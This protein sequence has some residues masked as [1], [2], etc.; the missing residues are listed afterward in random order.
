MRLH[1][2]CTKD[3]TP[4][5][6][7]GPAPVGLLPSPDANAYPVLSGPWASY[8]AEAD[9]PAGYRP[10]GPQ[11]APYDPAVL[12]RTVEAEKAP[13]PAPTVTSRQ[14]LSPEPPSAFQAL[15]G[16]M[17]AAGWRTLAQYAHGSMPHS[18]LGTP[19]AAKDSWALRLEHSDG[20]HACA[21]YRGGAWGSL[22]TWG[23]G[24]THHQHANITAFRAVVL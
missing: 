4:H 11:P 16:D 2:F 23:N 17:Q 18:K 24:A 22:F 12:S 1:P 19:L 20:R 10:D 5:E 9:V 7:T 6:L 21:V 15:H 14:G 8:P 3:C 13:Y